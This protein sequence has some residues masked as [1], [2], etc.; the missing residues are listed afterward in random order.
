MSPRHPG[1]A[2]TQSPGST[3]GPFTNSAPAASGAI[4][5]A[6]SAPLALL[7]AALAA[8]IALMAVPSAQPES[9]GPLPTLEVGAGLSAAEGLLAKPGE[10][11]DSL[12]PAGDPGRSELLAFGSGP[13][14]RLLVTAPEAVQFTVHGTVPVPRGFMPSDSEVDLLALVD[15]AG[16]QLTT[17]IEVVTRYPAAPG[18]V[19][20]ARVVELIANVTRP[21][22]SQPGDQLELDVVVLETPRAAQPELASA[23]A[24]AAAVAN[25]PAK[26]RDLLEGAAPVLLAGRDALGHVYVA[27]LRQGWGD[28]RWRRYGS[29][30]AEL[31][32]HS[33]MR[34]IQPSI[35]PSGSLPHLFGVHAYL[36]AKAGTEELSLDLR[37]HNGADGSSPGNEALDR[38]YFE[39]LSLLVPPGWGVA[40][41]FDDPAKGTPSGLGNYTVWPLVDLLDDGKLHV[42]PRQGQLERR[43]AL[44][45]LSTN[46]AT[47]K[48]TVGK[49]EAMLAGAG[50]AFADDA[51]GL[52]S[53]S[54]PDTASYL[55]H[56]DL[57]PRLDQHREAFAAELSARTAQLELQLVSGSGDVYPV[58]SEG[59]GW[60]HP[61][62]VAYG[63]MTGGD[64]IEFSPGVD[65]AVARSLDG[66][67]GLQLEHRMNTDRMPDALFRRDGEPS[68]VE[69][70]LVVDGTKSYVPFYFYMHPNGSE[71][72]FGFDVAPMHQIE[73]VESSGRQPEYEDELLAYQH[74]DIQH[75]V[76]YTGPAKALVWLGNDSLAADD[77]ALQAELFRMGYHQYEN[78]YYGHVQGTGLL[79]DMREVET[80]PASG[81]AIGRAEGW[82]ID[83]VA[84]QFQM[85]DDAT[86]ARLAPWL[87]D[88][89]DV[90]AAGQV[91]CSGNL[92]ASVYVKILGGK[93]RGRQV[94]EHAILD[95]GMRA[96]QASAFDG[97]LPA[98]AMRLDDVLSASYYA[99]AADEVW[100]PIAGAPYTQTAVGPLA[101]DAG[102]FC[103]AL[104]PDGTS[105]HVD[106][107]QAWASLVAGY[108]AT[109]DL[110][111]LQRAESMHGGALGEGLLAEAGHN[112]G[113]RTSVFR[114]IEDN[115]ATP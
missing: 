37:I 63:G 68:Q 107:Y 26:T 76:R 104:P 25:L 28:T 115:I 46:P 2:R 36:G 71:D 17:Q 15:P 57:L 16:N 10:S 96:L 50:L 19:P 34:P 81:F 67:R 52:W 5:P 55:A 21:S 39:S 105:E 82:G 90:I 22:S 86:R 99:L 102:T 74:H 61:Y 42:M 79:A 4:L 64:G 1:S 35:G 95:H 60:A 8:P 9:P 73:A 45:P 77:L 38:V 112:L 108:R 31:R 92:Q 56:G 113:N 111:F 94:I 47:M 53:W 33:L 44:V 30:H 48:A 98:L 88:V 51:P 75:L 110:M 87:E 65:T 106:A 27:P 70:W 54:N 101:A 3:R 58:V 24:M 43:L 14:A 83:A 6:G 11:S 41:A 59:L 89:A 32:S 72:P 91:P 29:Q 100:D 23:S 103:G 49:T 62:G 97:A 12:G 66:W 78:S 109:G 69:D 7:L 84:A 85:A 20:D 40:H 114:L 93:Y 13:V 80:N 18:D